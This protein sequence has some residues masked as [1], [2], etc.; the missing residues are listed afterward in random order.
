[1]LRQLSYVPLTCDLAPCHSS[2]RCGH[3]YPAVPRSPAS[4]WG[5]DNSPHLPGEPLRDFLGRPNPTARHVS[6][7]PDRAGPDRPARQH[8]SGSP[9]VATSSAPRPGP[10]SSKCG[11]ARTS[12]S[13]EWR[14]NGEWRD[15]TLGSHQSPEPTRRTVQQPGSHGDPVGSRSPDHR[16]SRAVL[17]IYRPNRR[18]SARHPASGAVA[19]RRPPLLHRRRR[20]E[21][22]AMLAKRSFSRWT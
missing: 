7:A 22:G 11:R 16:R 15:N 14:A 8:P 1:V 12:R 6:R 3:V 9:R 21:G 19:G 17:D 18:A 5:L 20:A 4:S 10:V 13:S 2:V